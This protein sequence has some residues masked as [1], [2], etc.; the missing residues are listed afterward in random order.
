MPALRRLFWRVIFACLGAAIIV[1]ASG[2][3]GGKVNVK[4]KITYKGEPVGGGTIQI[5]SAKKSLHQADIQTDGTYVVKGVPVGTGEVIVVW[6]DDSFSEM[7]SE[8]AGR[9]K[10]AKRGD[11]EVPE[12]AK[13]PELKKGGI[14]KELQ[15]NFDKV[16][17]KYK[18]FATSGL[19]VEVKSGVVYDIELKD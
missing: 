11:K 5:R 13:K 2:C 8:L 10:G 17:S 16:P 19:T 3:S 9:K 4:G 15:G 7:A 1:A 12:V 14:P 18:D 6:V